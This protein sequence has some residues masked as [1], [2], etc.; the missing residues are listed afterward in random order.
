MSLVQNIVI[1]LNIRPFT[2]LFHTIYALGLKALLRSLAQQP[3]ISA[4][5]GTGSF[6]EG[7]C[8]YGLSDIDLI[9]VFKESCSR[10]DMIHHDVA[11]S[12]QRIRRFFPFLGNWGEKAENLIFLS[13]IRDGFPV[14]ESFSIRSKQGRLR[15]LYG[16]PFPQEYLS[17]KLTLH[18]I[19]TEITTLL[20]LVLSKQEQY[21]SSSAFWQKIFQK[22]SDL[23]GL[24]DCAATAEAIH[25]H[26]ALSFLHDDRRALVRQH[27]Q[28]ETL[29][30][31]FWDFVEQLFQ[32]IGRQEEQIEIATAPPSSQKTEG[33]PAGATRPAETPSPTLTTLCDAV[34]AE[35]VAIPSMTLGM[36][37]HLSYFGI[38]T[39]IDVLELKEASYAN[40]RKVLGLF[41]DVGYPGEEFLLRLRNFL[42][43]IKRF[44]TFIDIVPLNPLSFANV[45][46][47]ILEKD[48]GRYSIPASIYH[49]HRTMAENI[50][51][52][53]SRTYRSHEGHVK[54]LPFPCLYMEDDLTTIRDA[55][56]RMRAFLLHTEGVEAGTSEVVIRMLCQKYPN[57]RKFL[58]DL[59]EYYRYLL[60]MN[61]R[62]PSA[63]NLYRCLHQF[64]TQLLA[65]QAEI[66][67]DDHRKSLGITVGIIT[68]NRADDLEEALES[69][70]QQI[71]PA[72]EILIVDN[73]S[74]DR[75]NAVCGQFQDRLPMSYYF[76]PDASIPAAR[77]MALERAKHE[78]VSFTDDD[79]VIEPEW[80][81]AVE[82]GFLRADNVGIVGGWV[83]HEPSPE[84]SVLDTYY[85]I[86]HHNKT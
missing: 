70:T 83:K 59:Q 14:P 13:E 23:A 15:L 17:E 69:L 27:C 57:C 37:P 81:N 18:E 34:Q 72:D 42:V 85:S 39:P 74:S 11:R 43:I 38:D 54:K 1:T 60:D 56:Y 16:S 35:Y 66:A 5:F 80:L 40:V 25:N 79:C 24:C 77:N 63:N 58:F 45:Y 65:G 4:V 21:T 20:R 30:P 61:S 52:A 3:E 76:L 32:A 82:R 78:I 2:R 6:F 49:E 19:S 86:F 31:L 48:T 36:L 62:P 46:A 7:K 9:L 26:E 33:F 12:Y 47:R 50:F 75:T 67:I 8:V 71:R 68:R 28:P 44:P 41:T 22:L 84:P 64:M 29:F 73:G 53:L 51:R 10:A 55:F